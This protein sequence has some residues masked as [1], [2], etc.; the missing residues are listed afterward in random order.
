MKYGARSPL[1]STATIAM[2]ALSLSGCTS[3]SPPPSSGPT[4]PPTSA[5]TSGAAIPRL[6]ITGTVVDDAADALAVTISLVAIEP[7]TAQDKSEFAAARCET[8]YPDDDQL[9]DPEARVVTMTASAT[10]LGGFA[11]WSDGRG[12]EVSGGLYDGP[13][14]EQPVHAHTTACSARSLLARPGEGTVRQFVSPSGWSAKGPIPDDAAAT[15]ASYGFI[16]QRPN[17]YDPPPGITSV[18]DCAVE[19]SSDFEAL[20]SATPVSE[21]WGENELFPEYCLYGRAPTN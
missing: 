14:W 7:L 15:L 13:I 4:A 12:A 20:A 18:T 10:A 1:V 2:L 6:V 3:A 11:G 5:A 19:S 8:G 17:S 16:A 21:R 9:A